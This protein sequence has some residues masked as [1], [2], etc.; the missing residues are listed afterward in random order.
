M[1][2]VTSVA[3][4]WVEEAAGLT[5]PSRVV[6][7]DGSKAEYDAL[8]EAMLRDG[9][10]LALNPRSYPNCYLHRSHPSDVAR[11]KRSTIAP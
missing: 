10:L 4:K 1:S 5:R 7:S 8:I 11:T 2:A 3:E 9:T 6:W